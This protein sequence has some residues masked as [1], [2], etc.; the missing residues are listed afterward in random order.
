MQP[1]KLLADPSGYIFTWLLGYSGGLGSIA[2]VLIADYWLVRRARLHLEDLY[3]PDGIYRYAGGW[4][5]KAVAAT[6]A[7]CAL[8]WG[9]LVVD[10]LKP[11]YSYAWF[12]GFFAAGLLYWS[13]STRR[14]RPL[15]EVSP[16]AP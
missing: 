12:V 10:V 14:A 16:A 13:L 2:G 5:W 6:L 8:A 3:L 7:G 11:L 1:W 9:G 4:N 15:P